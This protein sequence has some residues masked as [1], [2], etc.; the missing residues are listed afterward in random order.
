[1]NLRRIS[2]LCLVLI[3]NS[4]CGAAPAV[5]DQHDAVARISAGAALNDVT[6]RYRVGRLRVDLIKVVSLPN[7]QIGMQFALS[8]SPG[9]LRSCCSL[10]PRMALA[11]ASPHLTG[12]TPTRVDVVEP[13]SSFAASGTMRLTV[14]GGVPERRLGFFTVNLPAIHT[15]GFNSAG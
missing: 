4:A 11:G 1:V 2:G 13:R 7:D 14:F 12:S 10:F 8:A 15:A 3:V 9:S 5:S 6:G